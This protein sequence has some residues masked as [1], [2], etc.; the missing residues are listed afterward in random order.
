MGRGVA[1][2]AGAV[3]DLTKANVFSLLEQRRRELSGLHT[4]IAIDELLIVGG[5]VMDDASLMQYL[6]GFPDGFLAR[7]PGVGADVVM[8]HVVQFMTGESPIVKLSMP[9]SHR[10]ELAKEHDREDKEALETDLSQLLGS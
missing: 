9:P 4:Q 5:A 10:G 8:H 3:A 1:G 6:K 2:L 7:I